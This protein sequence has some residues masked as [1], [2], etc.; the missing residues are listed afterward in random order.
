MRNFVWVALLKLREGIDLH[1]SLCI[2]CDSHGSFG[3]W[4][5][6]CSTSSSYQFL[7]GVWMIHYIGDNAVLLFFC[8]VGIRFGYYKNKNWC[9][10]D[11]E[12]LSV[13]GED[14]LHEYIDQFLPRRT[15]NAKFRM[16]PNMTRMQL[17]AMRMYSPI[18]LTSSNFWFISCFLRGP[19]QEYP[20][21]PLGFEKFFSQ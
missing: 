14:T 11:R 16:I 13:A 18:I 15:R 8:P 17:Y 6:C 21:Q 4:L 3:E 9:G 19:P 5:P 20:R 7:V 2:C 10:A 1:I 12:Y